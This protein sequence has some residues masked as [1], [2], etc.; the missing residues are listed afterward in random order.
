MANPFFDTNNFP[1]HLKEG[2]A[3]YAILVVKVLSLPRIENIYNQCN[4][5]IPLS[6]V[7]NPGARWTEVFDL[8]SRQRIFRNL[9]ELVINDVGLIDAHAATQEVLRYEDPIYRGVLSNG[10]LFVDREI[11]RAHLADLAIRATGKSVLLV[12]GR[13]SAGKSWTRKLVIEQVTS[14]GVPFTEFAENIVATV[15]EV[16]QILFDMLEAS[17]CVPQPD[18]PLTADQ[19][20]TDTAW[21]RKV[22]NRLRTI[23]AA[24][25]RVLWIVVDDI[26][27][28]DEKEGPRLSRNIRMFFNQF[29]LHMSSSEAFALCF[30]LVLVDYPLTPALPSKW[31]KH[32]LI[33]D[34]PSP[35]DV[36]E[37]AV[38]TF[39]QRAARHKC[40][41]VS[42]DEAVKLARKALENVAAAIAQDGTLKRLKI[43][44]QELDRVFK[45][46]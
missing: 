6:Q 17:D 40:K 3:L 43:V 10:V 38:V 13:E 5:L 21:Y 35:E 27:E 19:L 41:E 42:K 32:I 26:G 31:E 37:D 14:L 33:E 8:L 16:V 20:E 7:L 1:W 25:K 28:Y 15:R 18:T 46:L 24:K 12:R 36:T 34:T 39:L 22:C 23:A 45:T 11:L 2:N 44:N 30:R 9:C 4:G 29:V